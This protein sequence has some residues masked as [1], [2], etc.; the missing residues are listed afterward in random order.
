[1]YKCN[2]KIEREKREGKLR[3]AGKMERSVEKEKEISKEGEDKNAERHT[4]LCKA[5]IERKKVKEG[6]RKE[7]NQVHKSQKQHW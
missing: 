5:K 4:G 1:M 7:Y 6:N 3:K 2:W